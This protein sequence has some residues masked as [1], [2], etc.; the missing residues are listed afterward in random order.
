MKLDV[1]T[2]AYIYAALWSSTDA[3]SKPL[4]SHRSVGDFAPECLK[5][6]VE[7]CRRFKRDHAADIGPNLIR[8]G[9]DFWF[10]R[11]RHG[12]GYWDGG[13]PDDVGER[14]TEAAHVWG[15]VDLYVGDDDKIHC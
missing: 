5:R 6:I 15:S 8:A 12:Y 4:D 7:D 3:D 2:K 13:W 9:H 11:N 10:T 14:L 1:F